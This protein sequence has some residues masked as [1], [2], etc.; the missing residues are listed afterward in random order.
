MKKVFLPFLTFMST[1]CFVCTGC[2]AAAEFDLSKFSLNDLSNINSIGYLSSKETEASTKSEKQIKKCKDL[3]ITKDNS[4]INSAEPFYLGG[5]YK[6]GTT[7]EL[8]FSSGKSTMNVNISAYGDVGDFV[9]FRY[10]DNVISNGETKEYKLE[11]MNKTG[12]TYWDKL[13]ITSDTST[14]VKWYYLSK[15]T[16]K[17]YYDSSFM[18]TDTFYISSFLSSPSFSYVW[19]GNELFQISEDDS[20]LTFTSVSGKND[21]EIS[22]IDKYGNLLS[23]DKKLLVSTD[24]KGHSFSTYLDGSAEFIKDP[25]NNI[26]YT[27]VNGEYYYIN[28][29]CEAVKHS[30]KIGYVSNEESKDSSTF[31]YTISKV[32][33]NDDDFLFSDGE[34]RYY[35]S[36]GECY[37][38][39]ISRLTPVDKFSYSFET[40]KRDITG[41]KYDSIVSRG[42]NLY[43]LHK[44]VLSKYEVLTDKTTSINTGDY[45]VTSLTEDYYGNIVVSGFDNSSFSNYTGYLS[46]DD[47]VVFTP[48]NE[49]GNFQTIVLTPIN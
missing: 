32:L 48:V 7:T 36:S 8:D 20:G 39:A 6:D 21:I 40:I 2:G 46:S 9:V 22:T 23:V 11:T 27:S 4:K 31:Q 3:T 41:D 16:G 1:L 17:L 38:G 24:R 14:D 18:G 44:G 47:K 5:L 28:S 30:G 29:A 12:L 19:K 34:S 26:F 45:S 15:K 35:F 49:T 25:Y 10:G 37:E 33:S 43:W 42:K 13:V